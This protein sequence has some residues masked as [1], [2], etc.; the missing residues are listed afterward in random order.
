MTATET[1]D[2]APTEDDHDTSRDGFVWG[3]TELAE[4]ATLDDSDLRAYARLTRR[5]FLTV[6]GRRDRIRSDRARYTR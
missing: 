3:T 5:R 2:L 4:V 6:R 1:R